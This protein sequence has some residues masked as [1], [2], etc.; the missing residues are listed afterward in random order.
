MPV[1]LAQVRGNGSMRRYLIVALVLL[2]KVK[3]LFMLA[4][5]LIPTALCQE[6]TFHDPFK[7]LTLTYDED[8]VGVSRAGDTGRSGANPTP[9]PTPTPTPNPS[10]T[11]NANPTPSPTPN[12]ARVCRRVLT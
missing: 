2:S 4:L 11:P 8:L 9:T 12:G 1:T 6:E 7:P 5:M 10:S 3:R